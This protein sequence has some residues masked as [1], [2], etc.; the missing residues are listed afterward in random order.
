M[1]N[2]HVSARD[3]NLDFLLH[4]KENAS[5]KIIGWL[6]TFKDNFVN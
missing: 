4:F 3:N 2:M 6:S 5:W 1:I